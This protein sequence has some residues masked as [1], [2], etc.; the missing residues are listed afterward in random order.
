MPSQD[1]IE[2]YYLRKLAEYRREGM[3]DADAARAAERATKAKYG[4]LPREGR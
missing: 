2:R 4:R 3:S 1:T